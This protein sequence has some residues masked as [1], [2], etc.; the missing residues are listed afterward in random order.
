MTNTLNATASCGNKGI[1]LQWAGEIRFGPA[2]FRCSP[3]GFIADLADIVVLEEVAW[4][5]D[6][7]SLLVCSIFLPAPASPACELLLTDTTNG[8]VR[9]ISGPL[10]DPHIPKAVRDDGTVVAQ[11]IDDLGTRTDV[12]FR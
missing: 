3:I 4:S 12:T 8:N 9:H 1:D 10:D 11:K 2:L 7:K 6:C 5:S